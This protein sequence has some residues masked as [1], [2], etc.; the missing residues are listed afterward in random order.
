MHPVIVGGRSAVLANCMQMMV[1]ETL[2]SGRYRLDSV[3]SQGGFGITYRATH[4]LLRKTVVVKTLNDSQRK[5]EDF[6]QLQQRFIAEAQRLAQF[7]HPHIVRVSDFFVEAGL[8]FIVMDYIPGRT[9]AEVAN[10]HPLP[11]SQAI[12]YIRQ[13]GAALQIIHGQGLLHRDVKPENIILRE[14]TETV[15]LIDF[16]IAREFTAGTTET[17][18]GL[19]SAGYAP[20]E[21]YLPRHR[22]TPATDIYALAATFYA[23][24]T[25]RP[26]VA[27]V[28]RD[29]LPLEDLSRFQPPISPA[30]REAVLRGMAIEADRRP[31]TVADWL[32]LLTPATRSVNSKSSSTKLS[33]LTGETLAVLPSEHRLPAKSRAQATG[34]NHSSGGNRSYSGSASRPSGAAAFAPRR[35]GRSLLMTLFLTGLIAG[36]AGAGFG[37]YLRFSQS[38][39]GNFKPLLKKDQSFPP[40]E[41]PELPEP[42]IAPQPPT[43]QVDVP[44]VQQQPTPSPTV[45]VSPSPSVPLPNSTAP[46]GVVTPESGLSP[47]DIPSPSTPLFTP[48]LPPEPV[49]SPQASPTEPVVPVPS[50]DLSVPVQPLEPLSIPS[51][52]DSFSPPIPPAQPSP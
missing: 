30:T 22:W 15:V 43:D 21:Q 10:R 29:R 20:V 2:Q 46:A 7:Q 18:T 48:V 12:Y 6:E 14:D 24:L 39:D 1:G 11:E 38:Q 32:A 49:P 26:P 45:Q 27:S 31:Q 34:G 51:P 25:G 37:L 4:T 16:G 3:L 8:P 40:R 41:R 50:P 13:V 36:L 17:N 5:Q 42:S 44:P 19:L 23:L 47:T 33:T 28:L 9:L 35:S 52:M